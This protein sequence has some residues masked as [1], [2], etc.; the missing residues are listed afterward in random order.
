MPDKDKREEGR[1]AA[2]AEARKTKLRLR[3]AEVI[4]F[5]LAAVF[6]AAAVFLAVHRFSN[7]DLIFKPTS[8]TTKTVETKWVVNINTASAEELMMLDGIGEA[9]AERIIDYRDEHGDFE[10]VWD[11]VNVSGISR[12]LFNKIYE[13]ITV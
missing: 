2:P 8:S 6:I 4:A 3:P 12:N 11:V 1:D 7:D 9:L 5:A 10:T 13:H